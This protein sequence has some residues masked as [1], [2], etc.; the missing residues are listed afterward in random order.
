M[1]KRKKRT[2]GGAIAQRL[3]HMPNISLQAITKLKN[4]TEIYQSVDGTLYA[5]RLEP[6]WYRLLEGDDNA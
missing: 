5:M 4:G 3:R 6:S 1:S 2:I